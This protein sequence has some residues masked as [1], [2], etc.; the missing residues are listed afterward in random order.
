QFVACHSVAN[1]LSGAAIFPGQPGDDN[2]DHTF[3][4]CSFVGSSNPGATGFAIHSWLGAVLNS[5]ALINCAIRGNRIGVE[6]QGA[7]A[8]A[9]ASNIKLVSCAFHDQTNTALTISD[10]VGG[11]VIGCSFIDN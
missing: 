2:T 9:I 10:A 1:G 6:I 4:N 5:I 3:V 7:Q 11:Q 8:G